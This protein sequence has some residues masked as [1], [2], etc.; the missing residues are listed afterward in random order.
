MKT[1]RD[2]LAG[3]GASALLSGC[4]SPGGLSA[5]GKGG[6]PQGEKVATSW[7]RR[8]RG[9]FPILSVPY[10][11]DGRIDYA[12]LG[13]EVRFTVGSGCPG[14]IWGQSNDAVDLLTLEEKLRGCEVCLEAMRWMPGTLAL[15]CNG[16]GV[17]DML[18]LARGI[19]SLAGKAGDVSV[20]LI[21]RPPSKGRSL[22]EVEAYYEALAGVVSR[23]VIIQTYVNDSCPTPP[24]ELLIELARRHPSVYGYIKEESADASANICR[25]VAAKPVVR[26]VFSAWGGWQWAYQSRRCGS[27]GLISER[28]AYAPLLAYIWRQMEQGDPNRT[29]TA[30]F[31]LY[32]LLIDQRGIP[33]GGALRGYALHYLQR[34]GVFSTT[35]SRAY[36]SSVVCEQ[37]T[38][39]VGDAKGWKLEPLRLS[40]RQIAELDACYDDMLHFLRTHA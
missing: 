39:S 28:C 7:D 10:F 30:A 1:R 9:P 25:E 19:E 11:E 33:G 5:R 29:L 2:L 36:Q 6:L 18:E 3:L 24:P 22:A 8:L 20:A 23:P 13:R 15:G 40:S 21:A 4:A 27:E 17:G 38:V 14:V 34:Q 26:T 16:E 31:A 12:S 32:R 37:G 35:W